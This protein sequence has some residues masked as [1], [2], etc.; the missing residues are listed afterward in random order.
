MRHLLFQ[1]AYDSMVT[2]DAQ[3]NVDFI[4]HLKNFFLLACIFWL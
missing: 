3:S 1:R 4:F 2:E